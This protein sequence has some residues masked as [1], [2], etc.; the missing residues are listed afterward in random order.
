MLPGAKAKLEVPVCMPVVNCSLSEPPCAEGATC[1]C[2]VG[3][4]CVVVGADRT[5]SCVKTST[6]PPEGQGEAGMECPCAWGYVC[7]QATH[8]CVKL[9][10]VMAPAT[11]CEG[12]R[13]Q[14]SNALPDGW[15]TCV[16]VAP[17]GGN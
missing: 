10:Q 14:P 5:T 8:A 13:C 11:D 1:S 4:A 3:S 15:G 6:L 17:K 7:S 12:A 2:P 9:C 16:G